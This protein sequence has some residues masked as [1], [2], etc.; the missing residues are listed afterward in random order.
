MKTPCAGACGKTWEFKVET[1]LYEFVS[2]IITKKHFKGSTFY[3]HNSSSYDVYFIVKQLIEERM[4]PKLV[5]MG[6][7]LICKTLKSLDIQFI[8]SLNHLMMAL[9]KLTKALGFDQAKGYFPHYFNTQENIGPMP[10]PR[11][12]G[13]DQMMPA[14]KEAFLKWYQEKKSRVF[15]FQKA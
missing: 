3:V 7:K 15:H 1:C 6:G 4:D 11:Y 2:L 13:M 8:D 14:G 12:Y 10:H 5:E 9:A